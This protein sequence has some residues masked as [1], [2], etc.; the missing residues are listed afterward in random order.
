M[1]MVILLLIFLFLSGCDNGGEERIVAGY[2]GEYGTL[3]DTRD[4]REYKTVIIGGQEW[5]AENLNYNPDFSDGDMD[6]IYSVEGRMYSSSEAREA[7]PEGWHLPTNAEWDGLFR[8]AGRNRSAYVSLSRIDGFESFRGTDDFGFSAS[9]AYMVD[10]YGNLKRNDD[11]VCYWSFE[12]ETYVKIGYW[13]TQTDISSYFAKAFYHVRCI[14]GEAPLESSS[15]KKV[16]V[17]SSSVEV[18]SSSEQS[19]SS[20]EQLSS[21]EESSSSEV[22]SSSSQIE[23]SSSAVFVD[24]SEVERGSFTDERDGREYR[25]VKIGGQTWMAENLNYAVDSSFCYNDTLEYCETYGRLYPWSVAMDSAGMFTDPGNGCGDGFVC[26]IQTRVRG[27]CPE[28]W[29]LP[30]VTEGDA[31]VTATDKGAY[32]G[33]ALMDSVLWN[34]NSTATDSYGFGGLPS[35]IRLADGTYK[36]LGQYGYFWL[37]TESTNRATYQARIFDYEDE[38]NGAMGLETDKNRGLSVRCLK[39]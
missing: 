8:Y 14:K 3:V 15:S 25:Y 4:G 37:S 34:G 23:S 12:Y 20:K 32:K 22:L 33:T 35:G 10:E 19:S 17:S 7:C 1:N 13:G 16:E 36:N 5:M 2:A 18:S 31:L 9:A 38:W 21:S 27:I 39:D 11:E 26:G 24:P 28:G 30:S 29:H 6:E